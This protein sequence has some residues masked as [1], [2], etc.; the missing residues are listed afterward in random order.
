MNIAN[1]SPKQLRRAA[2]IKEQIEQLQSELNKLAGSNEAS[3][4]KAAKPGKKAR[5]K[6]SAAVRTAIRKAQK[7]R[8]EK[9]KAVK[10]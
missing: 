3:P 5:R 2:Q 4:V 7:A 1:L 9:I 10:K 8:W 6:M